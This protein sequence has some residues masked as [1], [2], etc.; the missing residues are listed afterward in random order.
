MQVRAVCVDP[1]LQDRPTKCCGRPSRYDKTCSFYTYS[2]YIVRITPAINISGTSLWASTTTAAV[3]VYSTRTVVYAW[4]CA[5]HFTRSIFGTTI[6]TNAVTTVVVLTLTHR[7]NAWPQDRLQSLYSSSSVQYARNA[8]RVFLDETHARGAQIRDVTR[9][10][11]RLA[12]RRGECLYHRPLGVLAVLIQ[13]W[14]IYEEECT[15]EA[16]TSCWAIG[17]M[18]TTTCTSKT[19]RSTK[20]S[21]P[22]FVNV[23]GGCTHFCHP[24]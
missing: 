19:S 6:R 16:H 8:M 20:S 18:P 4:H 14:W 2:Y 3:R 1:L 12:F 5:Q 21:V 10:Y 7:Y 9:T 15:V 13:S 17:L 24:P 23:L 22:L 11:I